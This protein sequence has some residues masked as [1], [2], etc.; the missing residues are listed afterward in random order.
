LQTVAAAGG[1]ALAG[2]LDY[3]ERK[4]RPDIEINYPRLAQE[5]V[6]KAGSELK[7]AGHGKALEK[8]AGFTGITGRARKLNSQLQIAKTVAVTSHH[9]GPAV[10]VAIAGEIGRQGVDSEALGELIGRYRHPS[11]DSQTVDGTSIH[12][13]E[14]LFKSHGTWGEAVDD[15]VYLD[16][17]LAPDSGDAKADFVTGHELSHVKH[18]DSSATR[19]HESLK[20]S[21]AEAS[22]LTSLS[23]EHTF[24][25]ELWNQLHLA[26]LADSREV[27]LRAD[28][29]G[30]NHAVKRGHQPSEILGSASEIFGTGQSDDTYQEHPNGASRLKA[31]ERTAE[32]DATRLLRPG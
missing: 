18:H 27:E 21:V 15:R 11:A 1:T 8:I 12:L 5:Y 24:L 22:K 32:E 3:G 4:G 30:Y 13:V 25:V 10:A 16:S 14:K 20:E 9:L 28:K 23:S 17:E 19:I 6:S 7:E 29:D 26:Q 31:L 2:F